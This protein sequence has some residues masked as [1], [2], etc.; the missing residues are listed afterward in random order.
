MSTAPRRN[1]ALLVI[2]LIVGIG[3]IVDLIVRPHMRT[4][5][6]IDAVQLAAS[7]ACLGLAAVLL[8]GGSRDKPRPGS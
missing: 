6:A 2:L 7:V 1:T 3:G 8:I 5:R 4:Q